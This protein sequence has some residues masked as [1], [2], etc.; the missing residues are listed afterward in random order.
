MSTGLFDIM[1]LKQADERRLSRGCTM[2][3]LAQLE[4]GSQSITNFDRLIRARIG[5][6]SLGLSPPGLMLVYL[7]WLV[8]LAFSPGKQLDLARKLP[9]QGP[10]V[11]PL[12]RPVARRPGDAARHRAAAPGPAASPT[13]LAALALQPVPP[14]VPARCSSGCTTPT[15]GVPGCRRHDEEVVTF[16][17]RQLLDVFAPTNFPCTNPE[18]LRATLEQGGAQPGRGGARTSSRTGSGRS[19]GRKP[20]GTEPFPVGKTVAVTPG[21]GRLP[22]PPDRAD[23]VRARHRD[24]PGRA[25]PDRARLDHEVLHPRP[26][27]RTTRWSTTWSTTGTPCS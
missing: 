8:H 27:A 6:Q 24:R 12:R 10:A 14:V 11:R 22:Q 7:D 2:S 13:R 23:P 15:T 1:N 9:A 3:T 17:A 16:V 5:K 20:A 21:Q 4:H 18:I 19:L 26:V 25:G